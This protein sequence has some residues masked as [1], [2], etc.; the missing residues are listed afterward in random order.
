M[1]RSQ[2]APSPTLPRRRGRGH[3]HIPG[4]KRGWL[5][6]E[7]V[8]QAPQEAEAGPELLGQPAAGAVSA[9]MADASPGVPPPAPTCSPSL[10]SLRPG[11][12]SSHPQPRNEDLEAEVPGPR[13]RGAHEPGWL[14]LQVSGTV[15]SEGWEGKEGRMAGVPCGVLTG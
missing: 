10:H 8:G 5:Y 15:P 7:R 12:R 9:A 14:L 11:G 3:G 6:C 1:G 2:Q 4:G 13:G